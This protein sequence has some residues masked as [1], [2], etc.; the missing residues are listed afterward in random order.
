MD[1]PKVKIRNKKAIP[2]NIS[3]RIKYL[4]INLMKEVQEFYTE[5][6]KM[7]LDEMKAL[8]K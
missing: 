1:N 6:F 4:G 7:L 8:N 3:K 2:F 5:N